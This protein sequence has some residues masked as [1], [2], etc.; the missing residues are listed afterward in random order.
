MVS[1]MATLASE[2]ANLNSD[3]INLLHQGSSAIRLVAPS[4]RGL[5]HSYLQALIRSWNTNIVR[6]SEYLTFLLLNTFR[7]WL[8]FRSHGCGTPASA[9]Q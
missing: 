6:A 9:V 3:S 5:W 8:A 7:L 2:S 4:H 1:G